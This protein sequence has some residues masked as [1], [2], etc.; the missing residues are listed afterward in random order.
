MYKLFPDLKQN[1]I[2]RVKH[3]RISAKSVMYKNPVNFGII[4]SSEL[5]QINRISQ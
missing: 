3:E 2:F 1:L 4:L 5:N